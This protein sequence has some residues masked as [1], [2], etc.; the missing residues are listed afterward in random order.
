MKRW[1]RTMYL[2]ILILYNVLAHKLEHYNFEN[3]LQKRLPNNLESR[4][5]TI[6]SRK[7]AAPL[8]QDKSQIPMNPRIL[9]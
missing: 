9:K 3:R 4:I 7:I 6:I 5:K 8:W 1:T 2:P